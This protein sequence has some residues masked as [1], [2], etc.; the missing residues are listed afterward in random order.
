MPISV[1]SNATSA[2]AQRNVA[3]TQEALASNVGRLSSGQRINAASDDAAGLGISD[4]LRSEVRSLADASRNASQGASLLQTT[5]ASLGNVAD[6]LSR[7][8]LLAVQSTSPTLTAEDRSAASGEASQLLDE[9][10]QANDG[11]RFN[12]RRI[13]GAQDPFELQVGTSP[14]DVLRLDTREMRVDAGALG[15]DALDLT[16]N[17]AGARDAVA[18]ID[19]ALKRVSG[20]RAQVGAGE[21]QVNSFMTRLREQVEALSSGERIREADVAMETASLVRNQILAQAGVATLA[22]ANQL[23]G[24]ALS[25]LR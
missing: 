22:Q 14:A 2:A 18:R 3:R 25:L 1:L 11:T 5:E 16:G 10:K 13:F 8:R 7:M 6:I 17:P 19:S 21:F 20:F 9:L 15:V 4:K 23:P 24:S 12:E